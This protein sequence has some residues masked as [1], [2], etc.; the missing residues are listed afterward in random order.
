[1]SNLSLSGLPES[2]TSLNISRTSMKRIHYI[3]ERQSRIEDGTENAPVNI[4]KIIFSK[5]LFQY[6]RPLFNN[7]DF[8]LE[9]GMTAL[10]GESGSGKTTIINLIMRFYDIFG[11]SI[12]F[13]SPQ[14]NVD[15][16]KIKN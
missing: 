4:S 10:I 3:V 6:D 16:T 13:E 7:F 14:G 9:K 15:L 1:M 12:V 2:V 8:F 11:G 5:V